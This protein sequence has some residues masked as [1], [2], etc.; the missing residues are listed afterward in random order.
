MG[1]LLASAL[2]SGGIA[3]SVVA[4]VVVGACCVAVFAAI[5]HRLDP[6]TTNLLMAR[7]RRAG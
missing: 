6:A 5:A 2:P 1:W 3:V 4:S 7:L